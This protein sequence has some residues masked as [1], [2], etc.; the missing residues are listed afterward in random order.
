MGFWEWKQ[1]EFFF[2]DITIACPPTQVSTILFKDLGALKYSVV[3]VTSFKRF[4]L[5]WDVKSNYSCW[6]VYVYPHKIVMKLLFN[7]RDS[8]C[9]W[10]KVLFVLL[11]IYPVLF[12]WRFYSGCFQ[13][14]QENARTEASWS[15]LEIRSS[16]SL[17]VDNNCSLLRLANEIVNFNSSRLDQFTIDFEVTASWQVIT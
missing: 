5:A 13:M 1:I 9:W 16:V 12:S 15:L 8:G 14:M 4:S 7:H 17:Q 6:V 10:L 2:I 11:V 3:D